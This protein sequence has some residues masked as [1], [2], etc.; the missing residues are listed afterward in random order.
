VAEIVDGVLRG[1]GSESF[2]QSLLEGID[3]TGSESAELLLHLG[4][5]LLNGVEVG[6]VGRQVTERGPGLLDEFSDAIHFVSSQVI[7][8]DQLAGFQLWAKNLFQ[9]S[10]KD[11]SIGGRLNGHDGHPTGNADGSQY[12]QCA[13][14]TGGNS[15]INAS[16]V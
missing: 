15:L 4:P 14:V 1:E 12:G 10:Q 2:A 16:A 11:I 5:A 7:H 3:G 9:I 13:P 6:R 8:D